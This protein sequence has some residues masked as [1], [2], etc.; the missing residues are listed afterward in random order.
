M[1]D[2]NAHEAG[3]ESN[4]GLCAASPCTCLACIETHD[5]RVGGIPLNLTRMIVCPIC[6]DKRC[7]HAKDHNAPCAKADIYA[8]NLWVEKHTSD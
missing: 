1:T 5:I 8:H 3:T 4:D 2:Q 7:I 6:G